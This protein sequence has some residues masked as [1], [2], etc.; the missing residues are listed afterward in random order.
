MLAVVCRTIENEKW[1]YER[2]R[3]CEIGKKYM[4]AAFKRSQAFLTVIL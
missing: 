1:E 4:G 2:R 3:K